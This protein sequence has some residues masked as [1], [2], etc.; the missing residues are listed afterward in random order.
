MLAAL[1]MLAAAEVEAAAWSADGERLVYRTNQPGPELGVWLR[2]AGRTHRVFRAASDEK[3][4]DFFFLGPSQELIWTTTGPYGHRVWH[5]SPRGNRRL[6][7]SSRPLRVAVAGRFPRALVGEG[8][9][10]YLLDE[11]GLRPLE[12][13][14]EVDI[15]TWHAS[16]EG[17]QFWT[18]RPEGI[19]TGDA[20]GEVSYSFAEGRFVAGALAHLVRY[21]PD[22]Y[23]GHFHMVSPRLKLSEDGDMPLQQRALILKEINGQRRIVMAIHDSYMVPS[24]DWLAYAFRINGAMFVR[25][26]LRC[27]EETTRRLLAEER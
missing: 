15:A 24:P 2:D 16:S 17:V 12:A 27:D 20:V 5:G 19:D 18:K 26:L 25:S 4:G 8:A 1:F 7:E 11:G 10:L 9:S 13:P 21:Y 3:I 6:L 22:T 23:A 14:S